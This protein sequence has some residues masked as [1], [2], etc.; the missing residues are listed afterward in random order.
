MTISRARFVEASAL[1]GSAALL[2]DRL[3]SRDLAQVAAVS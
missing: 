1:G 2:L 3:I